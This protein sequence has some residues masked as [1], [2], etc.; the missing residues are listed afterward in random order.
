MKK[1]LLILFIF[2]I[3]WSAFSQKVQ[4]GLRFN[5]QFSWFNVQ[6]KE[7]KTY[8]ENDGSRMGF[9]YGLMADISFA[10]NY[11]L[12]TGLFHNIFSAKTA[13]VL[14]VFKYQK[15]NIQYI[16]IPLQLK[17]KTNEINN[18]IYYGKFGIVPQFKIN[19][20]ID[21]KVADNI[22]F[23]NLYLSVGGGVH[24]L[25]GGNTTALVGIT[26]NNGFVKI[27]KD[28]EFSIKSSYLS[29]DFGILF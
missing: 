19:G 8:V 26:F 6:N 11:A 20:E 10:E 16:E 12:T 2:G 7:N 14:D 22:G 15:W 27:N 29:M 9:S 17:M 25:I 28:N 4:L 1:T 3:Y 21:N 13:P 18:L 5:P 23:F 24:Y